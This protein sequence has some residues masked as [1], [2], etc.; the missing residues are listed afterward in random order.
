MDYANP[1]FPAIRSRHEGGRAGDPPLQG[2]QLLR[3]SGGGGR[4]RSE[5]ISKTTV[6]CRWDQLGLGFIVYPR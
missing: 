6:E 2:T 5:A 4:P 1:T 3:G